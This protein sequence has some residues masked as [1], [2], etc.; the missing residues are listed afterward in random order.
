MTIT[1]ADPT[2]GNKMP[3]PVSTIS[4]PMASQQTTLRVVSPEHGEST[5][6]TFGGL[7]SSPE[8]PMSTPATAT[9]TSTSDES[10]ALLRKELEDA[11]WDAKQAE[12]ALDSLVRGI[13]LVKRVLERSTGDDDASPS[14]SSSDSSSST[15]GMKGTNVKISSEVQEL[16]EVSQKLFGVLGSDLLGLVNAADMVREHARLATEEADVLVRDFQ[17]AKQAAEEA[18]ARARRAEKIGRRFY[19]ENVSL[20]EEIVTLRKQRR[21]LVKEVKSLRG[22]AEENN[23]RLLEEHMLDS[24]AIHEIVMKSPTTSPKSS[25]SVTSQ[26]GGEEEEANEKQSRRGSSSPTRD[27]NR[28]DSSLRV[29]LSGIGRRHY[30]EYFES[31]N[32]QS[33]MS[34]INNVKSH[35]DEETTTSPSEPRSDG[36]KKKVSSPTRSRSKSPL[37][38]LAGTTSSYSED[39]ATCDSRRGSSEGAIARVQRGIVSHCN[40]QTTPK[41]VEFNVTSSSSSSR[42]VDTSPLVTPDGSPLGAFTFNNEPKPICDPNVLRTLAMPSSSR[43]LE[44]EEVQQ[45]VDGDDDDVGNLP[46]PRVCVGPGLY[47]C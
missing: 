44:D 34:A 31:Q 11:R 19:K 20:K 14:L 23:W 32:S 9:S 43:Q 12:E 41:N 22:Q 33:S 5:S 26:K 35:D 37:P 45:E 25:D 1:T 2:H 7:D 18:N 6:N 30:A 17:T 10:T 29:S 28:S 46:S 13:R 21:V 39:S 27:M 38:S 16:S 36:N 47:E 42:S 15:K 8:S 4:S 40:G 24:M 3:A